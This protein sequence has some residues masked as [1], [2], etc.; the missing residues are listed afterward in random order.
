MKKKYEFTSPKS[1]I[2][3]LHHSY[4]FSKEHKADT[5]IKINCYTRKCH[6]LDMFQHM[7]EISHL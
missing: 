4:I 3:K 1:Q 5:K 6:I 2:L 7:L